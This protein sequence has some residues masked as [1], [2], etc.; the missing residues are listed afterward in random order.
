MTSAG[1]G[2]DR[3]RPVVLLVARREV[4]VRWRSRP[5]RVGTLGLML[6][7][8][9]A[10]LVAAALQRQVA[11]PT[12]GF[13]GSA[14]A[15]AQPFAATAEALGSALSTSDVESLASGEA[16]VR[17]GRLAVLVS[18]APTAPEAFVKEGLDQTLRVALDEAVKQVVLSRLVRAAGL[19]PR[20]VLAEV[21]DAGATVRADEPP[22]PDQG[23]D[24]F[25]GIVTAC[26][27]MFA[28]VAY[29][30][31]VASGVVEEKAIRVVE[32]ILATLRPG[33][34]LAGKVIGIG[35]VGLS[36]LGI[37]A[38]TA[39]LAISLTHVISLP[40]ASVTTLALD[41]GWFLLGYGLY[42]AMF[43]I[44]GALVSRHEDVANAT[45][46]PT[47]LLV[48]GLLLL[49]FVV[50]P[51]PSSAVSVLLSVL[52]PW[53]PVLMPFRMAMTAV[54]LWQIL[55]GLGLTLASALVLTLL[56][57]RIYAATIIR[58]GQR[59]RL[60]EALRKR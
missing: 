42:A 33:Q 36:Q 25:L 5:L 28:L 55:L 22:R 38:V 4:V 47:L 58:V 16:D 35:L 50:R 11:T 49:A 9:I 3:A 1:S 30:T 41:L 51:D 8:V 21:A 52:P 46:F 48:A 59:V 7:I 26:A 45:M 10:A 19:D 13:V 57:G 43:A 29:G 12:V 32:I 14:Q 53:T 37:L 24:L 44:S 2:P 17:S 60:H 56:A 39:L 18:G 23:P 40:A 34:L 20:T 54:P 6:G 15:L 27:L 31:L